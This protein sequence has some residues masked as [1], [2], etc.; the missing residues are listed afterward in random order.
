[1][2][3]HGLYGMP[4]AGPPCAPNPRHPVGSPLPHPVGQG[5]HVGADRQQRLLK[6]QQEGAVERHE[7]RAFTRRGAGGR[8]GKEARVGEAAAGFGRTLEGGEEGSAARCTCCAVQPLTVVPLVAS[9]VVGGHG[10]LHNQP[11]RMGSLS[12]VPGQRLAVLGAEQGCQE[13]GRRHVRRLSRRCGSS[14]CTHCCPVPPAREPCAEACHSIKT[15][16][17]TTTHS[18]Y[19]MYL[20]PY[21]RRPEAV[22]RDCITARPAQDGQRRG[23]ATGVCLRVGRDGAAAGMGR[24]YWPRQREMGR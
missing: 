24:M 11:A 5:L 3:C 19:E 18:S 16:T 12:A 21:R 4:P 1:M 7:G 17:K 9:R 10:V 15:T 20:G 2:G 14:R 23:G 13:G 22:L 6:L 8:G